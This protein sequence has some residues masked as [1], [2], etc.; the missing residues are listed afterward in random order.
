M[1]GCATQ[2][3]A[4]NEVAR[5]VRIRIDPMG[6]ARPSVAMARIRKLSGLGE[7]SF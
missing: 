2:G 3:K 5:S 4:E 6:L 1:G 7:L